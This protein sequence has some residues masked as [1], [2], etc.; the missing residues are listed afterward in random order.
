ME[1]F[2]ATA[3]VYADSTGGQKTVEEKIIKV[4]FSEDVRRRER[5]EKLYAFFSRLQDVVV[6]AAAL[7][8]ASPLMAALAIAIYADDP[9][10][11]P[12]FTQTRVGKDGREF[13]FYKFRSMVVNAESM[14]DSL[15]HQN[16]ADGPA[17]KIKDD[18]RITKI[19]RFIRKTS[20]DEL[21]QLVNI[22][23]GD[24]KL[25]GPRPPLPREVA[26]YNDYQ[27]KRLSVTP[28]LTCYWQ[29]TPN[30]NQVSFDE[31][32]ALDMK[33][34]SER[35]LLTDWKIILKTVLAVF[36]GDGE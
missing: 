5:S 29:I 18:P 4:D 2:T 31:W 8:A 36:R 17:F 32:M 6:S 26:Q 15:M 35:S 20:L 28:G 30:R 19:G 21:P 14:V 27:K 24:M 7:V 3:P 10:G 33:Y 22:L 34:I 23:K 12:I 16:E 11:S 13:K 25:V 1:M 9:N